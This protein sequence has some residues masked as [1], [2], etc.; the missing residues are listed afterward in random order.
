MF[1]QTCSIIPLIKTLIFYSRFSRWKRKHDSSCGFAFHGYCCLLWLPNLF[2]ELSVE[3]K[4]F[5]KKHL[6]QAFRYS[7]IYIAS[8][9]SLQY[10]RLFQIV[11]S[12]NHFWN[13]FVNPQKE[14]KIVPPKLQE[15]IMYDTRRD[16]Q[17]KPCN[18]PTVSLIPHYFP[19]WLQLSYC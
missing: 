16:A 15:T 18:V 14:V 4:F 1:S 13:A 19:G 3:R 11:L 10:S 2:K 17:L 7:L 12:S 6:L 8:R 9:K 5:L